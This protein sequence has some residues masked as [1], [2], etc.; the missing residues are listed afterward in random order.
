M[1][2]QKAEKQS[3]GLGRKG[4]V[5]WRREYERT[6]SFFSPSKRSADGRK[7]NNVGCYAFLRRILSRRLKS[8]EHT[9]RRG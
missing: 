6:H 8:A 1:V 3:F 4:I 9:F 7:Q 2:L 5:A